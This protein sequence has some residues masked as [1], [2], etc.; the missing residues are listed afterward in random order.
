MPTNQSKESIGRKAR[1][2]GYATESLAVLWLRIK[3]YRII[4]RNFVTGRG[5]GAGEID[6]I[7][8][9]GTTLAFIEVK[10]RKN[11]ADA[12]YAIN[13]YSKKRISK[14][15]EFFLSLHSEYNHYDI[16]FD[17]FLAGGKSRPIH[18]EDAWRNDW[19]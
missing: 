6:I 17:A 16:R 12:A 7:A 3:G 15:A 19:W 2:K 10:S 11:L 14:A 9:R 8:T 13:D 4:A 5:S 1:R 18:I